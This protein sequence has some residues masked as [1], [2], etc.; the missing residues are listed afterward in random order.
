MLVGDVRRANRGSPSLFL[1]VVGGQPPVGR[2]G[3]RFEVSPRASRAVLRSS[4]R[5]LWLSGR[6][7]APTGTL[8]QYATRG[9][10]SHSSRNGDA[11]GSAP[12]IQSHDRQGD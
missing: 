4:A 7:R 1:V 12:A 10:T 6:T 11:A 2:R 9:A 5:S 3:K 8:S